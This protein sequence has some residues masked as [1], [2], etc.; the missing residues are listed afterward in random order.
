VGD[1]ITFGKDTETQIPTTHRIVAKSE[2]GSFITKG[3]NNDAPDPITVPTSYIQGKVFLTVPYLG[4]TLDFAKKPLGF[5]LLVGIPA[6]IVIFDEVRNIYSEFRRLRKK[7]I[8]NNGK[9]DLDKKPELISR[10]RL[11]IDGIRSK[12]LACSNNLC[13]Q[14]SN[15]V[16]NRDISRHNYKTFLMAFLCIMFGVFSFLPS[17]TVSYYN[18]V[19]RSVVNKLQAGID[20]GIDDS[21]FSMSASV[22]EETEEIV[23]GESGLQENLE[24]V[25]L[26]DPE[27]EEAV[28]PEENVLEEETV[29]DPIVDEDS[30]VA[31]DLEEEEI[32]E[33][34]PE[35][36]IVEEDAQE[37]KTDDPVSPEKTINMEESI[38]DSPEVTSESQTP[39]TNEGV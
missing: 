10:S 2:T 19:E 25:V 36:E 22:M 26:E 9:S 7:R 31:E 3:D 13:I 29:Q 35:S 28:A 5:I 21:L 30:I 6:L 12:S 38:P 14:K 27:T 20:Y 37:D 4:F 1:I 32:I 11:S 8:G 17:R 33:E 39:L 24:D 16:L 18:E 15:I 23:E 34:E